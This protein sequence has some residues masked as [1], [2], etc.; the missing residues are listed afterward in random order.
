MYLILVLLIIFLL[1]GGYGYRTGN[2]GGPYM[3]GGLGVV[4]IVLIV[5]LLLGHI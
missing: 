4:L 3:G 2:Y 1:F 5:L